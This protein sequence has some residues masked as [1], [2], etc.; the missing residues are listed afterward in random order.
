LT[1]ATLRKAASLATSGRLNRGQILFYEHERA[2]GGYIVSDGELR[3][4]RQDAEGREQT[5]SIA[6][7]GAVVGLSALFSGG[8]FFSTTIANSAAEI[9]CIEKHDVDEL[10]REDPGFVRNAARMLANQVRE[11]ARAIESLALKSV[12]QL[13]A[14]YLVLVAQESGIESGTISAMELP[15]TRS[16]IASRVGSTREVVSRAFSHLETLGLIQT[17]GRRILAIPD[18][19]AVSE[20]SEV[21]FSSSGPGYQHDESLE[22]DTGRMWLNGESKRK[23]LPRPYVATS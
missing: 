5:L 23:R 15:L 10:C 19:T 2:S 9:S 13:V 1:D 6:R 22:R 14:E 4:F 17:K 16:A 11:F 21:E 18:I 7:C 12:E 8:I 3:S 20:F